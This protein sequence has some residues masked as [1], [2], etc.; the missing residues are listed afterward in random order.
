MIV[1]PSLLKLAKSGTLPFTVISTAPLSSWKV[2]DGIV[3]LSKVKVCEPG[4]TIGS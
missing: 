4:G 3:L 2:A 1:R